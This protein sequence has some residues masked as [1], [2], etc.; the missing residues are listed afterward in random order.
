MDR[1][2]NP[3]ARI[4]NTEINLQKYTQFTFNKGGKA[5]QWRISSQQMVLEQLHIHRQ[6]NMNYNLNIY[7]TQKINSMCITDLS[8]K[9][10]L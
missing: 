1:Y 2:I 10:R 8:I 5:I 4:E 9:C 3:W 7:L 6:K